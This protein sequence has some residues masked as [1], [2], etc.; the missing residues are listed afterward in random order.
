MHTSDK[1]AVFE[2][3]VIRILTATFLITGLAKLSGSMVMAENFLAWG[4][5]GWFMYLVGAVEVAGA[6]L[7][8]TPH[9]QFYAA[10]ILGLEMF[11][12]FFT[13]WMHGQSFFAVLPLAIMAFMILIAWRFSEEP[14]RKVARLLRWYELDG[15]PQKYP[16]R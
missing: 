2:K 10:G 13:H 11:G 16:S 3:S 15:Q 7:L 12:A 8:L 5:P 6:L 4:Y 1:S 9:M 14:V